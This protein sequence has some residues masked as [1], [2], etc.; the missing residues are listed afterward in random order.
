MAD[1]NQQNVPAGSG[2][3]LEEALTAYRRDR[4]SWEE[5]YQDGF[6]TEHDYT[7]HLNETEEELKKKK[8]YS[9]DFVLARSKEI[10]KQGNNYDTIRTRRYL[11]TSNRRR[12]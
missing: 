11:S 6:V 9:G 12:A 7:E 2:D 10:V 4:E 1:P 8:Y 5:Y 3:E